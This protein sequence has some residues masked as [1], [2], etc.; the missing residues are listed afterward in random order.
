MPRTPSKPARTVDDTA[1]CAWWPVVVAVLVVPL[2]FAPFTADVFMLLKLLVATAAT[3]AGWAAWFVAPRR[4]L[5]RPLVTVPVAVLLLVSL[6]ATAF[7][8]ARATSLLGVYQRYGGVLPLTVFVAFAALVVATT[9]ERPERI[10][11]IG[12][13]LGA[14][15]VVVAGYALLQRAGIDAFDFREASGGEVRFPGSTLGNSNF[16]GGFSR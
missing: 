7:S 6:A 10:A 8:S 2:A 1:D 14:A 5:P 12:L 3:V 9:W 15:S 16:A 11:T 13:L 4:V